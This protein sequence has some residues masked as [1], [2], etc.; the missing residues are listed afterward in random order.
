[1][2]HDAENKLEYL[3]GTYIQFLFTSHT[4][5]ATTC[6]FEITSMDIKFYWVAQLATLVVNV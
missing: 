5:I 3:T 2:H 4:V 6:Q 1:M